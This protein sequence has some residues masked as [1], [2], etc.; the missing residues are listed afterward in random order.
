MKAAWYEKQ[1]PA[2]EVL[3]VGEM[4]DPM[5]ASGEVRIRVS[6]SGINPGDIKKREDAFGYGMPYPR[7]I[8]HSDGAGR[9]DQVGEGVSPEWVGRSVW[10]FGAQSYR[11]FG[12]AAEFTVVPV[13]QAVPMPAKVS[14]EQGA[15]LGIPGITAHRAVHVAGSVNGRTVLVQGAAGSVGMCA[16]QLARQAGAHVI[17]TVMTPS[18]EETASDAGAQEVVRN[19]HELISRLKT[20]APD[21]IDHIVEVAFGANVGADID[22]LKMGGSIATYATNVATPTIP[23]WL[24][25]FKNIRLFFLGSDDFPKDAKIAAARDLNAALEAGWSGFEIAERIPLAEIARAHELVEHPTRRGRIVV[26]V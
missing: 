22:L 11:P 5:P 26:T 17:G 14:Q 20:L 13:E 16:V 12:T 18:E 8:P 15:C 4:P 24:M 3:T 9:V 1:G 6:A 25:V 2:R 21:G 7:I 23:F 19:D 10:C